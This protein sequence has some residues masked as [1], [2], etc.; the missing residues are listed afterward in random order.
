M[1]HS[2]QLEQQGEDVSAELAPAPD[3]LT[4]LKERAKLMGIRF[5]NNISVEALRAKINAK[6]DGE[7]EVPEE[8]SAPKVNPLED[9]PAEPTKTLYQIMHDKHMALIRVRIT[10]MDPKKADLHGE[11]FTIANEYLGTVRRFVPYGEQTDDGWHL[12]MVIYNLLKDKKFLQVRTIKDRRTGATRVE[13]QWVRE[14]NLEVLPPLTEK[15]LQELANRQ[16]AIAGA[17]G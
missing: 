17:L 6:L 5:S 10:N 1:E 4:V 3:E 2:D 12:P 14:F 9:A 13:E 15:E 7:P 8:D 11:I 16:A